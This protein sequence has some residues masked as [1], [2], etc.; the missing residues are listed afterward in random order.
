VN[1][2]FVDS[3]LFEIKQEIIDNFFAERRLLEEERADCGELLAEQ[4][5]RLKKLARSQAR[6]RRL[7]LDDAGLAGFCALSG[8]PAGCFPPRT[9]APRGPR[10]LECRPRGLTL[11]SRYGALLVAAYDDYARLSQDFAA[12]QAELEASVL[13]Y[14]EEVERYRRNYDILT[15]VAVLNRMAPEEIERRH[16][17]GGNYTPEE[18]ASLADTLSIRPLAVPGEFQKALVSPPDPKQMRSQLRG[19]A[20]NLCRR[21]PEE[22]KAELARFLGP[23]P[24]KPSSPGDP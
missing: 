23:P 14:N 8:L 16:W 12:G 4:A 20:K 2:D 9:P 6:L 11:A 10:V 24:P 17:L 1:E 18:T 7:L 3:L 19:L 22:A 21:K 13:A 5:K 15:I